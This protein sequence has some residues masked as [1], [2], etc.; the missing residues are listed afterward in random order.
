MKEIP[1]D[2]L[3]EEIYLQGAVV[4]EAKVYHP[5]G[6]KL[7]TIGDVITLAQA[8]LMWDLGM[9][10]VFFL[11]PGED[12]RAARR[13]LAVERVP[14]AELKPG[15]I[16]REDVR[17]PDAE[18]VVPEGATLDVHSVAEILSKGVETVAIRRRGM[19]AELK[20]ASDYVAQNPPPATTKAPRPD[21]RVTRVTTVRTI[22]VRPFLVPRARIFVAIPDELLRSIITN[23][24]LVSGHEVTEFKTTAD[25]LAATERTFPDIV[26]IDFPDAQTFCVQVRERMALR[27]VLVLVC[28]EEGRPAEGYKALGAGA[29]EVV[30]KPPRRDVLLDKIR[31]CLALW[32]PRMKLDP[33]IIHQ[34]RR[35]AREGGYPE[36]G[37]LDKGSSRPL[38]LTRADV[39]DLS[40]GGVKIEYNVLGTTLPWAYSPHGVHP[41]HTLF[42]F[43]KANPLS[44][45]L[46]I[47][48]Q[49]AGLPVEA[50]ARVLHVWPG[51]EFERAGF[52]FVGNLEAVGR[53]V[54]QKSR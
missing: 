1:V 32:R 42:M 24:L 40:E 23:T 53:Y 22:N 14:A 15:D 29:N 20:Q 4:A 12:D 45:E 13:S 31:G 38:A 50:P 28:V 21:T 8:R 9:K 39:R 19:Q 3:R 37:I 10:S 35:T 48:L 25:A 44:R 5:T 17:R 11:E 51:G 36:C 52:E 43:A 33:C 34:R 30:A 2:V 27:K 6:Q 41:R 16:V 7:H 46:R 26:L 49:G 54:A 47:I 18:L